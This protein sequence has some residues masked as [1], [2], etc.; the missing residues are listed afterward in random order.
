MQRSGVES[1]MKTT[2]KFF[3]ASYHKL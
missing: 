1:R 2:M 3:T